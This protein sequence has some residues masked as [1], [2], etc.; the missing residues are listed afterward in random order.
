VRVL[1]SLEARIAAVLT[2]QHGV[3][4]FFVRLS[5]R[6][7]KDSPPWPPSRLRERLEERLRAVEDRD[8]ELRAEAGARIAR[9]GSAAAAG[10]GSGDN[11]AEG[12]AS[13]GEPATAECKTDAQAVAA[14]EQLEVDNARMVALSR[15]QFEMFAVS[16]AAEAMHRLCTSER[17]FVDLLLALDN[18]E[19]E[20]DEWSVNVIVREWDARVRDDYEFRGFVCENSL[21]ALSQYNHYCYLPHVVH[22][23]EAISVAIRSFWEKVHPLVQLSEYVMDFAVLQPERRAEEEKEGKA[24]ELQVRIVE[25][26]PY[27]TSTGASLFNWSRDHDLL[28]AA[29]PLRPFE[30]RVHTAPVRGI[31]NVVEESRRFLESICEKGEH[32]ADR[33][34]WQ[35]YTALLESVE[36]QEAG[37]KGSR[38]RCC[39]Q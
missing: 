20:D 3:Q 18:H 9:S 14:A 6:S 17:V 12:A 37:M 36:E 11:S 30:F 25:L 21:R 16:D 22:E 8:A 32:T 39:V 26:N 5:S 1:R 19:L 28:R 31:G 7:P 15:A 4:Q 10:A 33:H 23:R 34:G 13:V 29:D 27:A 35:P 2:A 38:A 24:G